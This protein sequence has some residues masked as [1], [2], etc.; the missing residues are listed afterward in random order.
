MIS[1]NRS[2]AVAFDLDGVLVPDCD[3]MPMIDGLDQFLVMTTYMQPMFKPAGDWYIITGRPKNFKHITEQWIQ[4]HFDNPPKILFHDCD[5]KEEPWAYK[6]KTLNF[7]SDKIDL[8]VESCD[9]TTAKLQQHA[10]VPTVR[11]ADWVNSNLYK[12]V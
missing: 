8:Y 9:K 10:K 12:K 1:N 7:N 6:T 5:A 4:K 2:Y 11:F 3:P